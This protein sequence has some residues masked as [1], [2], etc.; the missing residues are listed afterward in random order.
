MTTANAILICKSLADKYGSAIVSD[1]DWTNYLD[2]AQFEVLNRL[3]PDSLGGVV[4]V[5]TNSNTIEELRQLIY[6]VTITPSSGLITNTQ[7][8]NALQSASGDTNCE[9]FRLLNLSLA[10]NSQII[11]Y[12]KHNNINA[13][14][15]NVFKSPSDTNPGYVAVAQGYQIYPGIALSVNATCVKT[16][17]NLTNTGESLDYSDYVVNQIIFTA[18]KLAGVQIRDEEIAF[19]MRNTNIDF[20]K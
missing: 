7:L 19:D 17:R 18:V 6:I 8:N 2:I 14:K 20:T 12:I 3:F 1:T 4:D 16:P 11:R 10:S 5:E 15:A 13:Y 9:I